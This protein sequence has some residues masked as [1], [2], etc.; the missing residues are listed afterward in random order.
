M[1]RSPSE[2][3]CATVGVVLATT[4]WIALSIC[5]VPI[6][7]IGV[8]LLPLTPEFVAKTRRIVVTAES[9]A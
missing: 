6:L 1:S 9:R 2:K 7:G 4:L 5:L 8:F 3:I